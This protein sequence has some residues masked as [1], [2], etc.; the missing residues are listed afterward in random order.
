MPQY[1]PWKFRKFIFWF[2]KILRQQKNINF[3]IFNL[4]APSQKNRT[5]RTSC[6][7]P[8]EKFLP[9]TPTEIT[10]EISFN[11][12]RSQMWFC[13]LFYLFRWKN[14]QIKAIFFKSPSLHFS[15]VWKICIPE[16]Q[17][18]EVILVGWFGKC[19]SIKKVGG[20]RFVEG[21]YEALFSFH[22]ARRNV[23]TKRSENWAWSQ[24]NE[25]SPTV[26]K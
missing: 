13:W 15:H 4:S 19:Q 7:C 9:S 6:R 16:K 1:V 8:F 14:Q 17:A 18:T 2:M 20:R 5:S 25:N 10:F 11:L 26:L 24:V 23:I 3:S 22:L 12:S 21:L